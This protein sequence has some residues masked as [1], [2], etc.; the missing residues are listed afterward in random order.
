[1][2]SKTR[3]LPEYYV[4]S[5][6]AYNSWVTNTLDKKYQG[7]LPEAQK[8]YDMIGQ[9]IACGDVVTTTIK[10]AGGEIIN[11]IHDCTL[12]RPRY[13]NAR[14]QGTKGIWMGDTQTIYIEN[15]H[16]KFDAWE[17]DA[18]WFDQYEHPLWTENAKMAEESAKAEQEGKVS[19]FG[20]HGGIDFIVMKAFIEAVKRQV[21]PPIDVYDAAAWMAIT[22]LS[23]DSIALGGTPVAF[24][25]FTNGMWIDR[26]PPVKSKYSL[27][28]IHWD[29]FK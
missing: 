22:C 23:E 16:E 25:D 17:S 2:A 24:P 10:C 27:D 15:Q 29:L 1:V 11:I 18:K 19:G 7:T 20:S 5:R 21:S 14:V 9:P 12:P 8:N 3:G 4:K 28:D 26:E 6:K 13:A